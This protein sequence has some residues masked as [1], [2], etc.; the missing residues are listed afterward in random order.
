MQKLFRILL[1]GLT[2]VALNFGTVAAQTGV[3]GGMPAWPTYEPLPPMPPY[4][5]F[6]PLRV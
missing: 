6:A 2:F 1:I 4:P 3:P 5:T